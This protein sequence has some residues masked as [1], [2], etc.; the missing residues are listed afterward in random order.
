M[1]WFELKRRID[2]EEDVRIPIN[3]YGTSFV[4]LLLKDENNNIKFYAKT[5]SSKDTLSK[6][7]LVKEEEPPIPEQDYF[8]IRAQCNRYSDL[9]GSDLYITD[10][11]A[12]IE[13]LQPNSGIA[14]MCNID[15][16]FKR[17]IHHEHKYAQKKKI[18]YQRIQIR[19]DRTELFDDGYPVYH[20]A[21]QNRLN[22][23]EPIYLIDLLLF[24]PS[25]KDLQKIKE[26]A[27]ALIHPPPGWNHE[28]AKNRQKLL[29]KLKPPKVSMFKSILDGINLALL[30]ATDK[31][32]FGIKYF[33]A[34][35]STLEEWLQPP[36][37]LVHKTYYGR[38][39][40]IPS[41]PPRREG[42][43][44]GELENGEP[45]YITINDLKKH[46][47]VVGASGFGKSTF[48]KLLVLKLR[49]E[50]P[51]IPI[52][53]IDPHGSLA[54]E[55]FER[56]QDKENVLYFH[57]DRAPFGINP[58]DLP[59]GDRLDQSIT[60]GRSNIIDL[61]TEV[62][63][64]P[65]EAQYV[66]MILRTVITL[67]YTQGV[68]NPTVSLVCKVIQA[69][70]N[71]DDRLKV[72]PTIQPFIEELKKLDK[73]NPQSYISTLARLERFL[74]DPYIKKL[75]FKTTIPFNEI[76]CGNGNIAKAPLTL[77]SLPIHQLGTECASLLAS[78]ILLKIWFAILERNRQ[79]P[80]LDKPVIVICD[81]FQLFKGREIIETILTQARKFNLFLIASHQF[82]EQLCDDGNERLWRALL[83]NTGFKVVF[84]TTTVD[85][86]ENLD[87]TFSNKLKSI[88]ANLPTGY[89]VVQLAT[90]NDS[91]PFVVKI[92]NPDNKYIQ[93]RDVNNFRF[94]KYAPEEDEDP[95]DKQFEEILNP[96]RK[97]IPNPDPLRQKIL[98]HTY[99]RETIPVGDL[100]ALIPIS[101]IKID[102][103]LLQLEKEKLITVERVSSRSS[104]V[105]KLRDNVDIFEEFYKVAPSEKGKKMIREIVIKY[106]INGYYITPA[107]QIPRYPK[108]DLIA[109]PYKDNS[110]E[111]DYDN[112]I[113]IEIEAHPEKTGMQVG[114]NVTKESVEL[115]NQIH[116]WTTKSKRELVEQLIEKHI[117]ERAIELYDNPYD[118]E[119][120][121]E[122]IRNRIIIYTSEI[123][124]DE[125]D[126][127][128][129][130]DSTAPTD[131]NTNNIIKAIEEIFN[132][133]LKQEISNIISQLQ[134]INKQEIDKLESQLNELKVM[135]RNLANTTQ[136]SNIN[137]IQTNDDNNN[138][139]KVR[140]RPDTRKKDFAR[141]LSIAPK[142]NILTPIKS[143]TNNN[144]RQSKEDKK[145]TNNIDHTKTTNDNANIEYDKTKTTI[146]SKVEKEQDKKDENI[147]KNENI[148]T[149]ADEVQ[150]Q[151]EDK[152]NKTDNETNT[153]E[154]TTITTNDEEQK[155][156]ESTNNNIQEGGDDF[157]SSNSSGTVDDIATALERNIREEDIM[158][159]N[160]TVNNDT[161][162]PK[163]H[164]EYEN[165]NN[166]K[167]KNENTQDNNLKSRLL[168]ALMKCGISIPNFEFIEI[169]EGTKIHAK[170]ENPKNNLNIKKC[171]IR[172]F[173]EE[174][175]GQHDIIIEI[176]KLDE[177]HIKNTII[178]IN[179]IE[180]HIGYVS[181]N[182]K[183]KS[184][185]NSEDKHITDY[186]ELAIV[187]NIFKN[188]GISEIDVFGNPSSYDVKLISYLNNLDN[189]NGNKI[190]L[191]LPKQK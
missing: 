39:L 35:E 100:Y 57:P 152:D 31:I 50:Y 6:Y 174:R 8:C 157:D 12:L 13:E 98:F 88:I 156:K 178:K 124:E 70:R 93:L 183:L 5:E 172:E 143:P 97:M 176:V 147:S 102:E 38:G 128:P 119:L 130:Q 108:P 48:L 91:T 180:M 162:D 118:R 16:N 189:R 3:I 18:K 55:I 170:F 34:L 23:R 134:E 150:H 11:P 69:I 10:L 2:L 123:E 62:L 168:E 166:I 120:F 164:R 179:S 82:K 107:K 68:R 187:L 51:D 112:A 127:K 104:R 158:S 132:Q 181:L 32:F 29:E 136:N 79:Y 92:D 47:H 76:V 96:I 33:S 171:D 111:L 135:L 61:F 99:E 56:I 94:V 125:E 163:Y 28:R 117:N 167:I 4:L 103:M 161:A 109:I 154:K 53:V 113:A 142:N 131:L 15:S 17:I 85:V 73:A 58:F 26:K 77:F 137:T 80:A 175:L 141:P 52:I 114:I 153:A 81:E 78:T 24:A 89:A 106:F 149:N 115:F 151:T 83:N 75:T 14:V 60:I 139:N 37:P 86:F 122:K 21:L 169:K 84:K 27:D 191:R 41:L 7:F 95:T 129:N 25:R 30:G 54:D 116:V 44:I 19:E 186:E 74:G 71:H 148:D 64:L 45:F 146:D 40:K 133:K 185:L 46:V 87:P 110:I 49:E 165:I 121:K 182:A 90:S 9:F 59:E 138:K 184:L 173:F 155:A 72:D 36:N 65:E 66:K 67:I 20:D 101:H 144:I 160:E 63:E 43:R 188:F 105:V 1:Q 177:E 190:L 145:E 22:S 159:E 42:I 126:T 140:M